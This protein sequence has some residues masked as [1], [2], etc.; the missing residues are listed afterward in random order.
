MSVENIVETLKII[1][2]KKELK[3]FIQMVYSGA[4]VYPS[5]CELLVH[6]SEWESIKK[7]V[8]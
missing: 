8:W 5:C 6:V 1:F 7:C 3:Q 2:D 4:Y